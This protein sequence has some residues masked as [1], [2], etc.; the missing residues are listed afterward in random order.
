MMICLG[1]VYYLLHYNTAHI[2]CSMH[3]LRIEFVSNF[4]S[5]YVAAAFTCKFYKCITFFHQI[6]NEF[7]MTLLYV[8][9]LF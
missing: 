9:S 5:I 6:I 2:L 1:I 4:F 7:S 8:K 3:I